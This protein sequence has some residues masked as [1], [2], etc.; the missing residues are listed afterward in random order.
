MRKVAK[1]LYA[2]QCAEK[3]IEKGAERAATA[4]G[5]FSQGCT[6]LTAVSSLESIEKRRATRAYN[7]DL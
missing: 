4:G 2:E 3:M 1:Q 6:N 7:V 5:F